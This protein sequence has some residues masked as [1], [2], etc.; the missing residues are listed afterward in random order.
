MPSGA[1]SQLQPNTSKFWPIL[2]VL[3]ARRYRWM[4]LG[5][6]VAYALIYMVFVGVI[7][8]VPI[9][10]SASG[11]P[12]VN[13]YSYAATI[14][15]ADGIWIAFFYWPMAFITISSFLAGLNIALIIYGRKVSKSCSIGKMCPRGIFGL[16]PAFLT[17]ALCCGG[18]ILAMI[19]GAT[20]FSYLAA[21]NNFLAPIS[22][23]AL[24]AGT[25][26]TSMKI[27]KACR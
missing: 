4:I 15:P 12:V 14:I 19:V 21:Y 13:F 18:G 20:A 26:L 8:Y 24:A 23:A 2:N 3:K 22:S 17:P 16:L 25:Y 9:V 6:G 1:S 5:I 11:M 10:K 7:S 27:S